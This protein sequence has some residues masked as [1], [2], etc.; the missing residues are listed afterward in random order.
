MENFF[1]TALRGR[2]AEISSIPPMKYARRYIKFMES[3]VILAD[4]SL[5]SIYEEEN[6]E[7]WEVVSI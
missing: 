7:D 6:K 4:L 2:N 3:H 1:K 5:T